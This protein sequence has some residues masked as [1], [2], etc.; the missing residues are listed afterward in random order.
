MQA[1]S[2]VSG[3]RESGTTNASFT[4]SKEVH[5]ALDA[6]II[7]TGP[8][9]YTITRGSV[10]IRGKQAVTVDAP[11]CS[12]TAP[13]DTAI[14]VTVSRGITRLLDVVDPN[15]AI[16]MQVGK[17]VISLRSGSETDVVTDPRGRAQE[18]VW[19]DGLAR[20]NVEVLF[21][22]DAIG[23]VQGEFS[24]VAALGGH[25]LMQDLRESNDKDDQQLLSRI[26]KSAAAVQVTL[27]RIKGPYVVPMDQEQTA[28][29]EPKPT[30]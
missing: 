20:R 13:R 23:I 15:N 21:E 2:Y 17:R 12:I 6:E 4:P 26:M 25:P 9:R 3:G 19:S 11:N 10:L 28:S 7:S 24:F 29:T 1:I 5:A 14:I 27:D 16:R 18:R 30:L 8:S 22:S